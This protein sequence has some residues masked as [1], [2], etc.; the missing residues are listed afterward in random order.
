M[1]ELRW[2]WTLPIIMLAVIVAMM[3]SLN[4]QPSTLDKDDNVIR[5]VTAPESETEFSNRTLPD[6]VDLTVR[7]KQRLS[8]SDHRGASESSDATSATDDSEADS[9]WEAYAPLVEGVDSL[10]AA[11]SLKRERVFDYARQYARKAVAENSESFEALLLLAQLLPRGQETEA[12]YRRLVEK[13]PNSVEAL[14]GLGTTIN[15]E[16]PAES[17]PY[18]KA[19]I[20][21]DP[22]HG[23]AFKALGES[24]ERLGMYDEALKAFR[25]AS[26]LPPPGIDI[27]RWHPTVPLMHI[28]AIEAGNPIFKPILQ[29]TQKKYPELPASEE[30]LPQ[31]L[32]REDNSVTPSPT[33]RSTN[34]SL[35]DSD[36][37]PNCN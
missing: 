36:G 19:A 37:L 6:R 32:P 35:I 30:K 1:Q 4:R 3:F 20:A 27:R 24:Y 26:K 23:I 11:K 28:R 12:I 34:E 9:M 13:N 31:S 25:K 2:I 33:Q 14:Y 22:F 10:T 15:E 5:K 17:I 7:T 29:N 16:R 21:G 18:L 8:A